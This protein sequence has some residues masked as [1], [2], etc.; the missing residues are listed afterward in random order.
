MSASMSK[1]KFPHHVEELIDNM[2]EVRTLLDIHLSVGGD[3]PGRRVGIEVLN[4]S[5]VVLVVAC[6]EAFVEDLSNNALKFMIENATSH[7][8]FPQDVLERV[9][10]KNTGV[11]AWNLAGD[12]WKT[13]LTNN[14]KEVIAKTTGM[15]NTPKTAQVDEL[16]SKSIGLH[17]LSSSWRWG[18]RT[19]PAASKA[20]DELITLRGSIA[21]RVKSSQA[22]R[23]VDGKNAVELVSRLAAKSTNHV[24]EYV[25]KR[26][27]KYPW[28]TAFYVGAS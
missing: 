24:R 13:A 8:V 18:G 15:L 9:A 16:F 23:K 4:K 25:H 5:A 26:V 22:V 1:L 21:H 19:A 6:W 28:D 17:K 12:G 20:L 10:S 11:S 7:T 3:G 2:A 14:Y 27:G